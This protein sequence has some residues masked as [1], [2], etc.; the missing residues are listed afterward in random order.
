MYSLRSGSVPIEKRKKSKNKKCRLS[1]CGG[2]N[3]PPK[4]STVL[5]SNGCTQTG[6]HEEGVMMV[7]YTFAQEAATTALEARHMKCFNNN[8]VDHT[9]HITR[10]KK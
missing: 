1:C 7:L 10:T 2:C 5:V 6:G 3:Q 8:Q 9:H 4:K